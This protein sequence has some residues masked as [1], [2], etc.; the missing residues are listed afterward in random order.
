M[1]SVRVQFS[2]QIIRIE[3]EGFT[4]E[5]KGY[6]I[7]FRDKSA[8]YFSL[9]D[10]ITF[11]IENVPESG[12]NEA[13]KKFSILYVTLNSY[14][15][16]GFLFRDS[17]KPRGFLFSSIRGMLTHKFFENQ[18]PWEKESLLKIILKRN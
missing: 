16:N 12:R 17:G 9:G 10:N 2:A 4:A 11:L 7:K 18:S 5:D 8:H 13:T 3:P 14:I 1:E 15:T 6:L